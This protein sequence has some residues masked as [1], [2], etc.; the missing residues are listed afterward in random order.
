[1]HPLAGAGTSLPRARRGTSWRGRGAAEPA[2]A[3]AL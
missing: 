3:G 1:M 2:A